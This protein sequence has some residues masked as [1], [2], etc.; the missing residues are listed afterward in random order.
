MLQCKRWTLQSFLIR[1]IR[2]RG[3]YK[4][5]WKRAG[6]K[7]LFIRQDHKKDV[8]RPETDKFRKWSM[9]LFSEI[10]ATDANYQEK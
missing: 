2:L 6:I 1:E 9:Y 3:V 8:C 10:T 5:V 4:F 7:K